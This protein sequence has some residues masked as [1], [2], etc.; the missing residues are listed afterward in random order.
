MAEEATAGATAGRRGLTVRG[1]GRANE[2]ARPRRTAIELFRSGSYTPALFRRHFT[3]PVAGLLLLAVAGFTALFA[4][5][6]T[7]LNEQACR[8][9]LRMVSTGLQL[10]RTGL[11][12]DTRLQT[13]WTDAYQ[14][15]TVKYDPRWVEVNW[16]PWM[17]E[18]GHQL[19]YV[20][21]GGG[22]PVYSLID[23]RMGKEDPQP[24]FSAAFNDL[25]HTARR[26]ANG[27]VATD[28]LLF[29]GKIVLAAAGR[30]TREV[31]GPPTS[32][33]QHVM[34]LARRVDQA[35]LKRLSAP[36]HIEGMALN[37]R[38]QR[39][40][41][42]SLRLVSN[43]G[44][45]LGRLYWPAERPGDH[46]PP[47]FWT[48]AAIMGLALLLLT[49]LILR[50][51]RNIVLLVAASEARARRMAQH[52]GLTG[53]V[54]RS[55]FR[56]ALLEAHA[57]LKPSDPPV[58]VLFI[59]LDGFKPVNDT[60][61]HAAGDELLRQVA[62]VL[63]REAGRAATVARMGGDEFAIL[64]HGMPQPESAEAVSTQI[65]VALG[66]PLVTS[67][68]PV[69]IGASVGI[70]FLGPEDEDP[71][72]ALRR[73][74]IAMYEAKKERAG[75]RLYS[76]ELEETSRQR[77]DL[78]SALKTA[79]T[80]QELALFYQPQVSLRDGKLTAV[81]ALL[82]WEHPEL[83]LIAP[84]LLLP[85]AEES[86]CLTALTDWVLEQACSH[87]RN[88]PDLPVAVN[89]A[90][91]QL[92]QPDI[93][94]R[95]QA[96]LTQTGLPPVQLELEVMESA[97][98]ERSSQARRAL[99]AL[100]ALGV[101]VV[102]DDYG[103]EGGSL[104]ALNDVT[105]DKIKLERG[106]VVRAVENEGARAVMTALGSMGRSL[107]V[108]ILAEGVE[109]ESQ[110]VLAR[111]CG[112]TL[113]QGYYFTHP[114]PPARVAALLQDEVPQTLPAAGWVVA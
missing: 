105:F 12:K 84:T 46:M 1:R 102:L 79:L 54:N 19:V 37:R 41:H 47:L 18:A 71:G 76:P 91:A 25:L 8:T 40:P 63:K 28:L 23:G 97:L 43:A 27:Q 61:G 98:A 101:R 38:I 107:N 93:V 111:A 100:R 81:E 49:W 64:L 9:A 77:R 15:V 14:N 31:D 51:S 26:S 56:S 99:H 20:I 60:L 94:E 32:D 106:I 83:G 52:D 29:D 69:K 16:G 78:A 48:L 57:R 21:D 96:I 2:Q 88:W 92:W 89:I 70:A 65:R 4:W 72:E 114:V 22:K 33:A 35:M 7:S 82:R 55:R 95:V 85:L 53:L 75:T 67:H 36:Y 3:A 90:P 62:A 30:I 59:D 44:E 73:A 34:I 103:V 6:V 86:G 5:S 80:R 58:A 10:H 112:C 104:S 13:Y 50:N 68:G 74:D 11:A 24:R 45:V 87:A 113:A 110:L 66:E 108:P 39:G 109:T 17:N 42:V